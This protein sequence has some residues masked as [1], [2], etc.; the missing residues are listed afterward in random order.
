[1]TAEKD[2]RF[3]L[4]AIGSAIQRNPYEPGNY[5]TRA[6]HYERLGFQDLAAG[7]AYKALLL[8][9]EIQDGC[10][11]YHEKA[12]VALEAATVDF[13]DITGD[14]TRNVRLEF[15]ECAVSSERR[16]LNGELENPP[17]QQDGADST[18]SPIQIYVAERVAHES[19]QILTRTL[20]ECGCLKSAY[21]F[22]SR[23]HQAFP[24]NRYFS[25][26]R[27]EILGRSRA[28]CTDQ[29]RTS[30]GQPVLSSM[31]DLPEQGSVRRDLYPWNKHE[32]DRFAKENLAELNNRL[33][34][35]APKCEVRAVTL[36]LLHENSIQSD[37]PTGGVNT[38]QSP[39]PSPKVAQPAITQL[40][41]FATEDIAPYENV[42]HERSI[43]AA[44]N[45]LNDTLCDAC[46]APLPPISTSV[47]PL[48]SCP[49]CEDTIF[50]SSTCQSL[51]L[52][53]YHPAVC[54]KPDF[55]L[56]AKDPSPSASASALYLALL[57]RTLAISQTQNRHPLDLPEIKYLW[58]DFAPSSSRRR[59]PFTFHDNILAPLHMLEKMDVD[60]FAGGDWCDTW[61]INTLYAK[62]RGTA[63][64]RFSAT[65]VRRKG[66]E[67]C[68]VHPMWCLANHS[69]APNVKWEWGGEIRFEARGGGD[70]VRWGEE[71]EGERWKGGIRKG[72]EVLNHYC[73][74]E[75]GVKERREWAV[76]ALGGMCMCKRCVWEDGLGEDDQR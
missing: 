30:T 52:T 16:F 23:G 11:E 69:C 56:L 41:L 59:L 67:V 17:N 71:E 58:G 51:A 61:V 42:L 66:P 60:I 54:T 47:P 73:D 14:W 6:D 10:G 9:D 36:P 24:N 4:E 25:H 74:V 38:R 75:L 46:S 13:D 19:Y 37:R 33:R 70:V 15:G 39:N 31:I 22:A 64:A 65:D 3:S 55:D 72:E 50:C 43:L 7:D 44:N 45:R 8:S 57:G 76:G 27:E 18:P 48:P 68:A 28:S 63:S 20:V 5:L 34:V 62:F 2:C 12:V 53:L 35:V 21:D 49:D 32:P 1:M 40:G 29:N 26:T